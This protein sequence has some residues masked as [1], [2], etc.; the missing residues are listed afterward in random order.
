M[1]ETNEKIWLL[2]V[3]EGDEKAFA[4][5]FNFYGPKLHSYLSGM[6][7]SPAAAEELVQNTFIRVWLYRE[8]LPF[9]G[10]LNAWIYKVASREALNYLKRKAMEIKIIGELG[11]TGPA[12]YVTDDILYNEMRTAIN[13]AVQSLSGRRREI[14]RMSREQGMKQQEIADTLGLSLMTVKNTLGAALEA[15]RTQLQER[16]L[17]MLVILFTLY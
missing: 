13:E 2:Q 12:V 15:I 10:N 16:G 8:Q 4:V 9:I 3:A 5:L 17:L 6:T 1:T 14:Y 7:K 11:S